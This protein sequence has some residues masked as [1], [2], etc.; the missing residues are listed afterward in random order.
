MAAA[1]ARARCPVQLSRGVAD[2][3]VS[4]DDLATFGVPTLTIGEAAHNVHVER[5]A[6]FARSVVA[7]AASVNLPS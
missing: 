3:M 1:L 5:P 6:R 4:D 2:W 7:F